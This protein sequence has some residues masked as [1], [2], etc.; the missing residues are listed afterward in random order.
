[1]GPDFC[2]GDDERNFFVG[3]SDVNKTIILKI[4]TKTTGSK[5]KTLGGF[6]FK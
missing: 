4:K 1:M 2:T 3:D 5:T 6:N